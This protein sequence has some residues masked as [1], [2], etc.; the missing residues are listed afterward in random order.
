M[1]TC[2]SLLA[3][4]PVLT[5]T[6][7]ILAFP[8]SADPIPGYTIVQCSG[9]AT[10]GPVN[11]SQSCAGI[12]GE[13]ATADL[14]STSARVT[15]TALDGTYSADY[16]N[17]TIGGASAGT[18][19][20]FTVV[21]SPDWD[22]SAPVPVDIDAFL[23]TGVSGAIDNGEEI[24]GHSFARATLGVSTGSIT[25][26][27]LTT[28][29]GDFFGHPE[30]GDAPSTISGSW[31]VNVA[32]GAMNGVAVGATNILDSTL[33]VSASAVAD[34][35][36][37]IDPSFLSAHPGFS[38]VFSDNIT[39]APLASAS[40]PEPGSV[41]LLGFALLALVTVRRSAIN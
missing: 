6:A 21:P 3:G 20:Y 9:S 16:E 11:Q 30:C 26:L 29:S 23:T 14:S 13:T 17:D 28:C 35:Y 22:F 10:M 4:V 24:V 18:V 25:D 39:N 31:T 37:Y 32:A 1:R 36:I 33:E 19:Y 8:A 41:W 40:V 38:L 5:L 2:F 34:P 27:G 7:L 12:Y 15:G